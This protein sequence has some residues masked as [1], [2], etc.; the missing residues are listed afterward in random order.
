MT[1]SSLTIFKSPC[2]DKT[3]ILLTKVR[4]VANKGSCRNFPSNQQNVF[5][6]IKRKQRVKSCYPDSLGVTIF[7]LFLKNYL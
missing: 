6:G 5:R 2:N 4:G 3:K 1:E 7:C